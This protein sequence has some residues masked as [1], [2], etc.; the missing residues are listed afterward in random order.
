MEI[1]KS[2]TVVYFADWVKVAQSKQPNEKLE[3]ESRQ[4]QAQPQPQPE[5]R[6][7]KE[8]EGSFLMP[9]TLFLTLT[10]LARLKKNPLYQEMLGLVG[11]TKP[12]PISVEVPAHVHRQVKLW[13]LG[14]A[15]RLI[16]AEFMS[17]YS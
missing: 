5:G 11:L 15:D 13:N 3:K 9:Y 16:R 6:L 1:A 4:P 8:S 12:L 17:K 14:E 7:E 10:E 2:G